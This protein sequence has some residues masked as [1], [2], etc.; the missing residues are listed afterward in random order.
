VTAW[1]WRLRTWSPEYDS[2]RPEGVAGPAPSV[3]AGVEVPVAAWAPRLPPGGRPAGRTAA[4]PPSAPIVFVDGVQRIDAWADL[5]GPAGEHGEALFASF[6]AGSVRVVPGHGA[7]LGDARVE[8]ILVGGPGDGA[9]AGGGAIGGGDLLVG[10]ERYR[11]QTIG[12]ETRLEVA[13]QV[14]RDRLEVEVADA[15]SRDVAD[16]G[17]LVVV[18][19][20]LHHRDHL[21]GA[22][23]YIK[24]HRVEYLPE[25]SLRQ[26]LV[27][28]G[29][30]ERTPLFLIDTGWLRWSWYSRLPV[31]SGLPAATGWAGL[32][33]GEASSR[34]GVTA[35]AELAD[36]AT[37]AIARFA[38]SP[39]KDPRAPQNLVPVGGLER[40]LRHRLGDRELLE[41]ALRAHL[42]RSSE[43]RS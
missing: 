18:D 15:G 17:G 8:R 37:L 41:R 33:R 10:G 36:R 19:G 22:V 9:A 12:Q 4:P 14:A 43:P 2:A 7:T 5:D 16:Q 30:G 13:L 29:P 1:R 21:A 6:A 38:S 32:V 26:V 11:C 42:I 3:D 28:L 40:L 20:P 39:V 34:L 24:S 25:P 35:A 31:G 23:G 27:D